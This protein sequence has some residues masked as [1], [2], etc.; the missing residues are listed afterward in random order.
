MPIPFE[1]RLFA[2]NPSAARASH[3]F[4]FGGFGPAIQSLP[5]QIVY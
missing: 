3:V 1:N 2:R 4:N 5:V